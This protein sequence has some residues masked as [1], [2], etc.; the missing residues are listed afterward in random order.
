MDKFFILLG[1]CIL[2][3]AT[4][5]FLRFVFLILKI[6]YVLFFAGEERLN[7]EYFESLKETEEYNSFEKELEDLID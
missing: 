1:L 2:L 6:I 4:M 7:K 3:L 5:Q